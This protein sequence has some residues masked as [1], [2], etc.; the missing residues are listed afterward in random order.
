MTT[1]QVL[2]Q[3]KE[4]FDPIT[5]DEFITDKYTDQVSKCCTVGHYKRL[6]SSNPQDYSSK[7]C[8]ESYDEMKANGCQLRMASKIASYKMF[9]ENYDIAW[10]NNELVGIF[11][12]PTPKQRVMAF[13]NESIKYIE[14]ET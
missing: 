6:T 1:L 7:N 2:K 5:E 10:I 11:N 8:I 9:G 14:N 3:A 4:L 12:Q 13:L